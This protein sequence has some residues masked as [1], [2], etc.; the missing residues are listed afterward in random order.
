MLR[1]SRTECLLDVRH[2]NFTGVCAATRK[3]MACIFI[4]PTC[5]ITYGRRN[6]FKKHENVCKDTVFEYL[7]NLILFAV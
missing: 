1:F 4:N 5:F 7:I 2:S 3:K 6:V